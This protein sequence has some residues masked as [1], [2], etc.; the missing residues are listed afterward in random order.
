MT[1]FWYSIQFI[2]SAYLG[3]FLYLQASVYVGDTEVKFFIYVIIGA[4]FLGI[5]DNLIN[6]YRI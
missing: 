6:E 5:L 4:L 1:S 3:R 2:V